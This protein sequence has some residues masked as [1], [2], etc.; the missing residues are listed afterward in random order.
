[1][2]IKLFTIPYSG[3]SAAIYL[4]WNGL[5]PEYIQVIPLELPGRGKRFG[6]G[7][8]DTMSE[9]IDDLYRHIQHQINDEPYA[10]YGHSLGGLIAYE[11]SVRL[12]EEKH[13]LP[14]RLFLSGCNPPHINYG[15][16]HLHML[17]DDLFLEEI[18]KLGG[19]AEQLKENS[20]LVRIFVPIIKADYKI[21]E[22][23]AGKGDHVC[24]PIDFSVFSGMNDTLATAKNAEEWGLYTSKSFQLIL[25]QGDH[26]FIHHQLDEV[27]ST[28][29]YA[30]TVNK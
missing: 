13:N 25:M 3:G 9:L 20:E 11:L 1:M 19:T 24:L 28:I 8:C 7:L 29:E 21:Y 23:Y 26:F 27:I 18:I 4:G 6:N 14:I 15:D 2:N 16:Q 5:L 30:L 22:L 17:P 12:M 10:I